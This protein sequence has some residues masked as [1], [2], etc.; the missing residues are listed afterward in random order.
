MRTLLGRSAILVREA[1]PDDGETLAEIHGSAFRRGWSGSE[2]EAL[3]LQDGVSA[4]LAEFRNAFGRTM[5]AGFALYRIVADESELLSIAVAGGCRR[6]GI[7]RRLMEEMLRRLYRERVASLHLEVE[8]E[9]L[10]A[11]GLYRAFEFESAGARPGYYV[12]GLAK[13][14]GALVMKRQLR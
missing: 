4:L 2:F 9:N 6:R 13:P 8:D 11:I 3:L 10:A 5:P 14:R 12:Q 7:A 1:G